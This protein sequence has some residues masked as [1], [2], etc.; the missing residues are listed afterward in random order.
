MS[1][2]YRVG[3]LGA[4][5]AVGQRFIQLLDQ[6]PWFEVTALAASERSAGKP[7]CD[8]ATWR[9]DSEIPETIRSRTIQACVPDLECDLVFSGLDSGVAGPIEEAFAAGGYPVISNSKNH[10]MEPDVPLLIPEVNPEH[11]ALIDVQRKNRGYSRGYIVTNPNCSTIGLT[12]ALKPLDDEYGIRQ[13]SVTTLQALSGAGYPGV[14]SLDILDNVVPYIGEEEEKMEREPL[15]LLGKFGGTGV[16]M[17]EFGISAQCNRVHVHDGHLECLSVALNE[18]TTTDA[19]ED[20][21]RTF[22][23]L[24]QELELPTAPARPIVVS[25]APDRPQPRKDRDADGGMG[26][27]IGRVRECGVLD[28]KMLVLVHNTIRGAAGTAILN[29]ELLAEQGCL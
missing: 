24:P 21:F 6:H 9:M 15:K 28:F 20:T 12:M 3:V 8:A 16:A 13:V 4:T 1:R 26:V 11:T 5:G 27:T 23:A 29:A 17:A 2:R 19:V 22:R 7:Y 25:D 14:S 10:R 18:R